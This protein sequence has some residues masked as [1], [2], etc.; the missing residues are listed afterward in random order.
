MKRSV[1]V[2]TC[3]SAILT[4][5]RMS[6]QNTPHANSTWRNLWKM[7]KITQERIPQNQTQDY[8]E[9]AKRDLQ[10]PVELVSNREGRLR[11]L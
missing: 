1:Q 2:C 11:P 3:V 6:P 9:N 10:K 5:N 8:T 4:Q 7:V